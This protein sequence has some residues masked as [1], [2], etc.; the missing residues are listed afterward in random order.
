MAPA[1]RVLWLVPPAPDAMQ[2]APWFADLPV[3]VLERMR[4]KVLARCGHQ[5][6]LE[7]PEAVLA[8]TLE[9]TAAW[10]P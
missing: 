3:P 6:L 9:T 8:A 2:R 1:P 4:P 10:A 5:G 7:R